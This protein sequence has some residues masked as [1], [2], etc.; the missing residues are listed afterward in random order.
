MPQPPIGEMNR[1]VVIRQFTDAPNGSFGTTQSVDT[2]ITRFAKIS[3]VSG[4]YNWG[5]KQ[6]GNEI[7]HRIWIRY[8]TGTKPEDITGAHVVEHKNRRYRVKRSTNWED[9]QR[10]TMIE[11]TDLGNIT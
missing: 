9:A 4:V 2:G 8:G 1:R 11:V 5:T 10:F 7:T 3:P 6:V